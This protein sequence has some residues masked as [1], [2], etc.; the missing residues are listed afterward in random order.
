MNMEEFSFDEFINIRRN[1][2]F[3]IENVESI[4]KN[5]GYKTCCVNT[6]Y[7]GEV[8]WSEKQKFRDELAKLNLTYFAYIK[9][10]KNID[11]NN[12]ENIYA[13]VAGKTNCCNNDIRFYDTQAYENL[14][15]KPEDV[16]FERADKAKKWLAAT[17]NDWYY[18]KVLIVWRQESECEITYNQ[19]ID[20]GE[21]VKSENL[22]LSIEADIGGLLGLFNS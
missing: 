20:K 13:L 2:L 12:D 19:A 9:F 4:L 3:T 15:K 5:L 16:V 14:L 21:I 6:Y 8:I 22:A 1:K 17:N 10:Y 7:K 11:K 18:E